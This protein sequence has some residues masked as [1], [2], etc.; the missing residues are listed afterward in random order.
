MR[1]NGHRI[2][3]E[4]DVEIIESTSEQVLQ[5]NPN[6]QVINIETV[7]QQNTQSTKRARTTIT[8]PGSKN[9]PPSKKTTQNTLPNMV[10]AMKE[11]K[12]KIDL[13]L[14]TFFF[15]CNIPFATI[16]SP[17]FK[18]LVNALCP[19]YNLPCI[20]T[21]SGSLLDKV[22]AEVI[23]A[24]KAHSTQHGTLLI[25]GWKNSVT[26]K[27]F[28]TAMVKPRYGNA[29]VLTQENFSMIPESSANIESFVLRCFVKSKEIYNIDIE[30]ST[31]DN[32]SNVRGALKDLN[33]IN[34]GCDAHAGDL[35]LK[36]E[37]NDKLV[38]EVISI[39]KDIRAST[40]FENEIVSKGGK[41]IYKASSVRYV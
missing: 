3:E 10:K 41:K 1:Q 30:A 13:L 36:T 4:G 35:Q 39:H 12:E 23:T 19:S 29:L 16:E 15:G 5:Q 32:A 2:S 40:A 7:G 25:D 26:N 20:K 38:E 17:F 37:S 18:A 14:A 27:K 11:F 28:V 34:Y 9:Q 31:S 21:L 33:V 24:N 22:Y 8:P 6:A